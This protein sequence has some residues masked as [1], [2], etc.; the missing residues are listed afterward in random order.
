MVYEINYRMQI[1]REIVKL[2][3]LLVFW[4]EL[5]VIRTFT[6]IRAR[7]QLLPIYL[8]AVNYY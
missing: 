2:F 4:Q 1:D 5:S 7:S 8:H 6:A 3:V